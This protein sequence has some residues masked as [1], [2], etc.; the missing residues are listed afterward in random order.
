M[1]DKNLAR[2]PETLQKEF[3]KR[4]HRRSHGALRLVRRYTPFWMR[5][6]LRF[7]YLI[8]LDGLDTVAGRR[9]PLVPPRFLNYAGFRGYREA[10]REYLGYFKELGALQPNHRVLD[11]GC[12][13]GRMAV[14]LT[15]YLS[16]SGSYEGLDIVPSGISW[17][18]KNISR[19]YPQFHFQVAD[20]YNKQYNPGGKYQAAEYRFPFSD[21]EFDFIYLTSVFTHL[22]PRDLDH[23]VAEIARMLKPGGKCLSTF[24]LLDDEARAEMASGKSAL[25][26]D[27]KMEGFWTSDPVTPETAVAYDAAAIAPLLQ[28]YCLLHEGT[29]P[30]KWSGRSDYLSYQDVVVATKPASAPASSKAVQMGS[31]PVLGD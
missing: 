9:D 10:G 19:R 17:C 16:T 28:R 7:P 5:R 4:E 26:F 18:R 13:I 14:G 20:I 1:P 22:L 23:Y 11:I 29:H 12:G 3:F 30:G 8:A 27:Y 31:V 6:V 25:K 24:F 21:G 15:G 2:A